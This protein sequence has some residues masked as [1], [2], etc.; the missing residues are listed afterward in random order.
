MRSSRVLLLVILTTAT[1]YV[2]GFAVLGSTVPTVEWSG[3]RIVDWFSQY[4]DRARG[5]AWTGAF[6]SMGLGIFGAQVASVLPRL[7]G[8]IFFA[9]A[10]GWAITAQVQ[11]WLW[12]GLALHPQDLDPS[13]ARTI[14]AIASYWGPLVNASSATMA[15]ALVPLGFGAAPILPKWLTWLCVIFLAEQSIETI[16]IFGRTGFLAPGGPMNVYVGG[17]IGFAWGGGVVNWAMKRMDEGAPGAA[18]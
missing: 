18:S 13:A 16:T 14:F 12:A 4:G 2:A 7:H 1:L 10:L 5:Y 15:A 17:V 11:A 3:D 9:G 6:V 8:S